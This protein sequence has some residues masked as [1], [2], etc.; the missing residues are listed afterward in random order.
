VFCYC[1]YN[2]AVE[3]NQSEEYSSWI[4]PSSAGSGSSAPSSVFSGVFIAEEVGVGDK[5]LG[6]T[7][8]YVWMLLEACMNI[9]LRSACFITGTFFW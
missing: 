7:A 6:D 3:Y 1:S 4:F 2:W 9:F 8:V 5:G